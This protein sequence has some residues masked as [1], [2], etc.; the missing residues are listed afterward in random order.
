MTLGSGAP[1]GTAINGESFETSDITSY[2]GYE[3]TAYWVMDTSSGTAYHVA[4]ARRQDNGTTFG[5]WQVCNLTGA[6]FTNGLNGSTPWDAHNVVSLG[7][8]QNNGTIMLAYDMHDAPL[9]YMQSSTGAAAAGSWSNSSS[10]L[11]SSQTSSLG[12]TSLSGSSLTY[13]MFVQ[14]PSGNEQLFIR[15]GASGGGSWFVFNYT[16]SS[17]SWDSGHQIDNG[18]VGSYQGNTQ[19]NAYPNGFSYNAQGQLMESFVW[20]ENAGSSN[21]DINYVYSSN[22]GA[23]WMNNA[24]LVV[25]STT[26]NP[27]LTFSLTSAGLVV[28]PISQNSSLMNQQCQA[29]DN[30]GNLHVIDYS[31][32]PSKSPSVNGTWDPTDCSYYTYW[33]DSL[34]DWH[35]EKIPGSIATIYSTRPK[36]YFDG[37]NNAIAI[38]CTNNGP[39]GQLVIAEASAATNWTDW[40]TVYTT[41]GTGGGY[42]SEAQADASQLASNGI[43]SVIMQDNPA[44]AG[45]ASAMH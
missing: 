27:S 13:P 24:G 8:D 40:Q 18:F 23:T 19:R 20:R 26:G 44:T 6:Q 29:V 31:L 41:S 34:G 22:G 32:D 45:G 39:G 30:N 9:K 35:R 3:Y 14:T 42:F 4:V 10:A 17:N 21:H 25:S 12:S 43:L 11:F 2:G 38:Y 28:A 7:I 16:G 37:N 5:A 36:L 1:Y 15:Q 33:R